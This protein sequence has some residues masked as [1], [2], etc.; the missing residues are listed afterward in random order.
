[1]VGSLLKAISRL[2]KNKFLP[3]EEF[4]NSVRDIRTLVS[5]KA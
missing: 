3:V 1:M 4:A 5:G 2:P